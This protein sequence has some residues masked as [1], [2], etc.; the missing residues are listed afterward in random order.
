MKTNEALLPGRCRSVDSD[1]QM[2]VSLTLV[3][4]VAMT[5]TIIA[6]AADGDYSCRWGDEEEEVRLCVRP[7][8]HLSVLATLR[9][10]FPAIG[11]PCCRA[12]SL[13]AD[14]LISG[15]KGGRACSSSKIA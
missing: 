13:A 7:C 1:Q 12:H 4:I 11:H 2:V 5:M 8:K 15:N 9:G 3:I 6:P 14:P 10:R